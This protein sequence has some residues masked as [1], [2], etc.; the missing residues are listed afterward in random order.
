MQNRTPILLLLTANAVSGFAQGI[1]MLAI[2]WYF[3]DVLHNASLFGQIYA[4]ITL[5]VI[6]WSLYAGALVDRYSR[7]KIFLLLCLICGVVVFSVAIMGYALGYVPIPLIVLVFATTVFN[8]NVHYPALYALSQE[9]TE[10]GNYG[11]L[12]SLIEIQG[13]A[14]SVLS[15]AFAAVLLSGAENGKFN[16]LGLSLNLPFSIPKWSL[17]DIFMLDAATY[18]IAILLI[19][20]IRY[21]PTVINKIDVGSVLERVKGGILFLKQ[22]KS[23]FVFGNASYSIFAVLLVEVHLL[24]P[25]YVKNYLN[26]GADVYASAEIYYAIGALFAGFFIRKVFA[27]VKTVSAIL[28]LI[29]LTSLL[30]FICSITQSA[31]YFFIFSMLIGITNAGTRVLR[32]TWLFQHIPNNIIGRTGSVFQVINIV[33][34][35]L[36][37]A[38]FSLAFFSEGT[39]VRWCYAIFGIYLMCSFSLLFLFSKKINAL[40][41][42]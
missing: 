23:L 21:T 39:N 7:K 8:Y 42:I 29:A 4:V 12:N 13:Q 17:S 25:L 38:L 32:V 11:R 24:L 27:S 2:P 5:G 31:L 3:I 9:I 19:M 14:T 41:R 34:R 6:I 35:S 16:L 40:E 26:S 22:N 37:I 15:G 28:M 10:K 36:F 18:F 20:G 30:L 33:T 1:S